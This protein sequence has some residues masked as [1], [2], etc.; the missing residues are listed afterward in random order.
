MTIL[1]REG[2]YRGLKL[3]PCHGLNDAGADKSRPLLGAVRLPPALVSG[4]DCLG[5]GRHL[6]SKPSVFPSFL[7]RE[8]FLVNG[9]K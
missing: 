9:T 2:S 3:E 4:S 7:H 5:S 6:V 1:E 8:A